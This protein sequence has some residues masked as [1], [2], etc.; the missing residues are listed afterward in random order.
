MVMLLML[1]WYKVHCELLFIGEEQLQWKKSSVSH[2]SR[3]K[4]IYN[5]K[6]SITCKSMIKSQW[7]KIYFNNTIVIHWTSQVYHMQDNYNR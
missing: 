2:A 3:W 5:E 6:R 1:G 7:K 4:N